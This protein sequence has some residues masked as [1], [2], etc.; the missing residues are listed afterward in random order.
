[1]VTQNLGAVILH[2][3][4]HVSDQGRSSSISTEGDAPEP[5]VDHLSTKGTDLLLTVDVPVELRGWRVANIHT[6]SLHLSWGKGGGG[7]LFVLF[8]A[9]WVR[10]PIFTGGMRVTR[11]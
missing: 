6:E 11:L 9:G 7:V 3:I 4:I 2:A 8:G 10:H 1:M 5:G